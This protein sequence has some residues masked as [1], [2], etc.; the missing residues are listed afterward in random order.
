MKNQMTIGTLDLRLNSRSKQLLMMFTLLFGGVLFSSEIMGQSK[1]VATISSNGVLQLPTNVPLAGSYQ[2]DITS[3][4]FAN[5]SDAVEFFASKQYADM[6]VRPNF[7]LNKAVVMLDLSKHPG[8][9]VQQWNAHLSSVT[10]A[11]PLNN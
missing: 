9:T 1:P 6:T 2:F 11:Q 8:W 3:M 10:A 4:Q 5:E 7:S